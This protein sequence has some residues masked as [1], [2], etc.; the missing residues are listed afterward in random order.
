VL[1]TLATILLVPPVNLA[2]LALA[3][4]L[5]A[6]RRKRAGLWLAGLWLAGLAL[7]ALVLLAVP[8]VAG[9]LLAGLER[10][11]PP[12]PSATAGATPG[13]IIVLGGDVDAIEGPARV[14]IGALTLERLRA[15]AA[16]AR[17]THLPLLVTGGIVDRD[18]PPVATLMAASLAADFGIPARWVEP[19]SRDTWENA[20]DSAAILRAAGIGSAYV[21]THAWH[22][23][24]ALIA[25]AATDLTVVP[26]P[27]PATRVVWR[28]GSFIPRAKAWRTSYY[29]LH[30]WIGCAWYAWGRYAWGRYAWGGPG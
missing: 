18:G 21:V 27:L 15:G 24:R 2:V 20:R 13:A 17:A 22:M 11:P 30:E 4:V 29:A 10:L 28:P 12:P 25:F 6:R 5:L 16:L 8:V 9:T 19:R 7:G 26:A 3:G 1:S 23:R 14:A